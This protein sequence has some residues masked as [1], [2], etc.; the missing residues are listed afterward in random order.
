ML[1]ERYLREQGVAFQHEPEL[2][3]VSQRIDYVVEHRECGKILLEIKDIE[4]PPPGLGMSAFDP[5]KPIRMHI[6]A[7]KKKFKNTADYLCVL[8][9]A[10]PL[11]SFVMLK[12]PLTITGA[13][14]GN[15][16]F[17]IPVNTGHGIPDQARIEKVYLIGEGKMIR[18]TGSQNTRIAAIVTIVE[19]RIW[20]HAM[21]K[22]INTDN[23][24]SRD[25]RA[26][27]VT[28]RDVGLPDFEATM[29]GV[30]VWEN[31][32]APR[33]LPKDL[34]KGDMDVWWEVS[35]D[36]RQLPTY[37]GTKRR[38]LEVDKAAFDNLG[39]SY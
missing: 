9:L 21:R 1:F 29:I 5:L 23:G 25:E 28:N 7:G 17:L 20:H 18:R 30:S 11:G 12:D 13:M 19:H 38:E 4:N 10:A 6:E 3:G 35:P 24:K 34:F 26:W 39:L 33:K 8:V 36:G 14:Y 31:A 22:Y 27:D 16:G 32:V 15:P 37:I 2:P